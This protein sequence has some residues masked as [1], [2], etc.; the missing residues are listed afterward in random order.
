VRKGQPEDEFCIGHFGKHPIGVYLSVN[1]DVHLMFNVCFS[2]QYSYLCSVFRFPHN[3]EDR[4]QKKQQC[5]AGQPKPTKVNADTGE[6][7]A[8]TDGE[9]QTFMIEVLDKH[10]GEVKERLNADVSGNGERAPGEQ[11]AEAAGALQRQHQTYESSLWDEVYPAFEN[12]WQREMGM[13]N[14]YERFFE[15]FLDAYT[16]MTSGD[17]GR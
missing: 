8:L 11:E 3:V 16:D 1:F 13:F 10:E 17:K 6:G 4:Q 5:D 15:L 7:L 2:L 9:D 14:R 12:C